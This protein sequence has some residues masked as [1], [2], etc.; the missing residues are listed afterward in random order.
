MVHL[1]VPNLSS[2]RLKYWTYGKT[3]KCFDRRSTQEERCS[4]CTDYQGK[5][6]KPLWIFRV[7]FGLCKWRHSFRGQQ[8]E[9]W[10]I[11]KKW[12]FRNLKFKGETSLAYYEAAELV[13]SVLKKL[14]EKDDCQ[15]MRWKLMRRIFCENRRELA[16]LYAKPKRSLL[17]LRQ[18]KI[19]QRFCFVVML[20]VT[21][22]RNLCSSI[23][24]L[25]LKGKNK[26][27]PPVFWRAKRRAWVDGKMF[28]DW[29]NN[30]FLHEV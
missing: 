22:C 24:P 21:L 16:R 10:K 19:P 11:K 2:S 7:M 13:P 23:D 28:M 15:S 25:V 14:G 5:D 9:V 29:S 1:L 26:N 4:K 6:Q 20:L 30:C 8:R 3:T 17:A 18:L 12:N 27:H